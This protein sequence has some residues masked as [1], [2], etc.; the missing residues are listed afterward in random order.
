MKVSRFTKAT[1]ILN[2]AVPAILLAWDACWGQLG[3]NPVNFAIRT[4]GI[5]SLIF[6]VLMLAITPAT[7]LSGWSGL[8]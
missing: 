4:T 6:L 7:R 2:G 3:A 8:A 1:V 5:L